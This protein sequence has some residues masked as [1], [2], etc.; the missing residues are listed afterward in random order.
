ML[1]RRGL[2]CV[3]SPPFVHLCFGILIMKKTFI[4]LLALATWGGAQAQGS[5]SG[6]KAGLWETRTTRMTADGQDMMAQITA[7]AEQMKKQLASLPPEQRKKAEAML[8][9]QGS[10]PMSRRICISPEMAKRDQPMVPRPHNA[11]CEP[12]KLERNGNRTTFEIACKQGGGS[13]TGKG[14]TVVAGD[15]ITT[16]IETNGKDAA[17]KAHTMQAETQM[18]F[19]GSNCGSVKPLEQQ[20][21]ELQGKAAAAARPPAK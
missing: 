21:K 6:L 12:P 9:P 8:P 1:H 2:F 20:M 18:K 10:D 5:S 15:L 11:E 13:M 19:L 14:E 16:K 7:A 17:G 4:A 3:P